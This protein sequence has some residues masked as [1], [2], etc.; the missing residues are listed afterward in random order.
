MFLLKFAKLLLLFDVMFGVVWCWLNTVDGHNVD[1]GQDDDGQDD[2]D[3][4][5]TINR[6]Q[7]AT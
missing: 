3:D 6:W 1:D 7:I 4:V 2:D 5:V